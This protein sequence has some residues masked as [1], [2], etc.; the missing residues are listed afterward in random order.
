[1]MECGKVVNVMRFK[2]T[3]WTDHFHDPDNSTQAT[4]TEHLC[5][6]NTHM[7]FRGKAED[8]LKY[9]H[10]AMAETNDCSSVIF[11][12]D[13]NSRLQCG[14]QPLETEAGGRETPFEKILN[15]FC[16]GGVVE[17]CALNRASRTYNADWDELRNIMSGSNFSCND[18]TRVKS[19]ENMVAYHPFREAEELGPRFPF[20]YKWQTP[21]VKGDTRWSRCLETQPGICLANNPKASKKK[22]KKSSQPDDS[23]HSAKHNP[24]WTDRIL[25]KGLPETSFYESR[26]IDPAFGSDHLPVVALF[27]KDVTLI[28]SH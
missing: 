12:G 3:L 4:V 17:N 19:G 1:M 28:N 13:F 5:L 15:E 23:K 18:G 14:A 21:T 10:D 8:R 20:T 26:V 7:S 24:A 16:D 6:M 22:G 27:H 2:V 11:V 9:I 25:V